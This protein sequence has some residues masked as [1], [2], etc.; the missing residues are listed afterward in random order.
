MTAELLALASALWLGI[1]TS[2][3]PC[4][5]ATNVA[6]V[7]VLARRFDN[8]RRAFAGAVAY[9]AGRMGVY[10]AIAM[11]LLTGMASMPALAEFLRTELFPLVGPVLVLGGMAALGWLPLPSGWRP[12]GEFA[13]RLGARGLIGEFSLGA[14][15]A[16]SFCPVSAALFFGSL[17]P[18]AITSAVPPVPVLVYGLGTALPIGAVAIL[19]VFSTAKVA[20]ALRHAQTL[21]KGALVATGVILIA[22]GAW[23]TLT[24]TFGILDLPL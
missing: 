14:L 23:L 22:V 8:R 1:L 18:L 16:L 12:N 2:I 4:P 24:Q 19:L 3:S 17:I 20:V 5:L 10:L 13:F 6:A 7:S 9:A 15:F 11:I 21:Q